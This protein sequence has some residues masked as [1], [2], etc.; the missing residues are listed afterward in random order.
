MELIICLV[1]AVSA[2][3]A[4]ITCIVG[5]VSAPTPILLAILATGMLLTQK[6]ITKFNEPTIIMEGKDRVEKVQIASNKSIDIP[7]IINSSEKIPTEN[8]QEKKSSMTYRGFHYNRLKYNRLKTF[9][10]KQSQ[11]IYR[12]AKSNPNKK[13]VV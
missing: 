3:V 10:S 2:F 4:A 11:V 6:S 7:N 8:A 5:L 12:G 1:L 13:T 9:D